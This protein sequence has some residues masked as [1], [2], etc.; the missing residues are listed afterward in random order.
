[1]LPANVTSK[2]NWTHL[3]LLIG[4]IAISYGKILNA[5]FV[6]WD[7]LDYVFNT[8]DIDSGISFLQIKHWFTKNYLGNYQP[9]PVFTYAL[10]HLIAGPNPKVFHFHSLLWHVA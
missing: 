4:A 6:R 1:M 9:L 3:A 2:T 8:R 7:D 5:G 10:D